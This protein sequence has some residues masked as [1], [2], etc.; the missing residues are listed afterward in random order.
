VAWLLGALIGGVLGLV[1]QSP[2]L[3]VATAI[4]GGLMVTSAL[5][6]LLAPEQAGLAPLAGIAVAVV[7]AVTQLARR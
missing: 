1:L 4:L 2:L 5:T 3:K 7:G 6:V